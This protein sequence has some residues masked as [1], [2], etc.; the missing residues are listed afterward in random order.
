MKRIFRIASMSAACVALANPAPGIAQAGASPPS[1]VPYDLQHLDQTMLRS[2][3][4]LEYRIIVSSPAGPPPPG[5][6]PVIYVVDGNA[7]TV[8]VSEIVRTNSQFG[9]RSKTEPAVVVGIGYPIAEAF[10][11]ERRAADLTPPTSLPAD[12]LVC[13]AG[14]ISDIA[15]AGRDTDLM[16]FI[17]SVVKPAMEARFRIDRNRQSLIGHSC[18]GLFALRTMLVHPRSYQTYVSLSPVLFWN[19]RLLAEDVRRFV[20]RKDVPA[21]LRVFIAAGNLEQYWTP[22]Y[23][24]I[25]KAKLERAGN[26]RLDP[27]APAQRLTSQEAEQKA[28]EM[29]QRLKTRAQTVDRARNMA[30]ELARGGIETEYVN[31]ADEDHFSVVPVELGRAVPYMLKPNDRD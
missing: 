22:E 11:L 9:L 3:A 6:F 19:G 10:D 4:G 30:E 2:A 27:A 13:S 29:E 8:M 16:D 25:V 23:R 28:S 1:A 31:F 5:G 18:G 12:V 20:A 21:N 15:K 26:F 7:W 24:A 14:K 17:E